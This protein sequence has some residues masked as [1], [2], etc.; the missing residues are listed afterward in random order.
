M[1]DKMKPINCKKKKL[2]MPKYYDAKTSSKP[3]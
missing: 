2:K 1:I 3:E